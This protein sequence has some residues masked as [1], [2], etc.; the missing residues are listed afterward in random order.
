MQGVVEFLSYLRSLDVH[1]STENGQLNCNAPKGVLTVEL[2]E[3]IKANKFQIISILSNQSSEN[4]LIPIAKAAREG[5]LAPSLQQERLWFL[6]Q[7]EGESSFYNL[8]AGLRLRGTLNRSALENSWKEIL[9]RH[10]VLR[11]A[12]VSVDGHPKSV[13]HTCADWKMDLHSLRE[14][15]MAEQEGAAL[16]F[17]RE[18]LRRPYDLSSAPAIRVCLVELA[19]ND[20]VLLFGAHHIVADGWSLGV[21]T[22]ELTQIYTA[23]CEERASPLPELSIQYLDYAHWHRQMFQSG[24]N[25]AQMAYWKQQ[26]AGSLP[27]TDL[28]SDRPRLQGP[29]YRGMRARLSLPAELLASAKKISLDEDVTLFTTFL[30]VFKIL[31]FR[32]TRETDVIVGS[33]AAGR[34]RPELEKLVGLFLTNLPLR[35]DLSGDPTVRELLARVRE[36]ALNAFS[37]QDVPFGDLVEA[38]QG[39]RDL[40]RTPLFQVMFILQNYR[41]RELQ[42]PDLQ[43][44]P[45]EFDIGT[46]R[47]DLT[48]EAGEVDQQFHMQWEY[49]SD[50]FDD[51][52]IRRMQAHYRRLLEAALAN[53]DQHIS[54]LEM[55]TREEQDQLAATSA[56]EA[57]D[58]PRQACIHDLFA[59]QAARRPEGVAVVFGS[60][61]LSYDE[62]HVRSNRL[63]NRLRALGIGPDSLAGV[64]L[65]RSAEMAV[66]ILGVLKA[67]GA[68]VP[69]D[70]AYPRDRV[71]FMLE[72]S[73]AKVLIT[74]ERL[75]GVLPGHLPSVICLDRDREA[76]RN[77]SEEQPASGVTPENLAYVIYTSGSTGKPKGVEI[78][79][80]S[81]VNFLTSMRREPGLSAH[82]RL[83][84]VTT[85]SF[86]IAGLEFHLPLTTGAYVVIAPQ[87]ALADGAALAQLM[88]ESSITVMQATP[89]TWRLLL[90]SGWEGAKGFKI[91]CG[92]EAIPRELAN[93]LLATG[94]EVWNLYGPTETTIWSTIHRI[95]SRPGSVPIGKPIAN[96][97]IFIL[98]DQRNLAPRGVPGELYIGGDGLARGYRHRAELT[99]ERFVPSPFASGEKLYRTGDLVRRLP[100]G[101][102]EYIGRMDHQV[103]LRGFRI[104]LGEI[105]AAIETQPQVRQAVVIVREDTPNDPRL[106]GYVTLREN[107]NVDG[108]ALRA[109][110]ASRLP[111]Y[112]LPSQWV[113]LNEFP[114]TPNRKVDRRALPVPENKEASSALSAPPTS[115]SEIKVAAIWQELLKHKNVGIHDNFFDLGGNSLLVVQLQ[116][117][118]RKHLGCQISLV[119]LFQKTTV[120][121]IA[122]YVDAQNRNS[123]TL[124]S[125]G[126]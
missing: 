29:S 48:V 16:Q 91:L 88:R 3:Q 111:E 53:P 41:S 21:I 44:A 104:E 35:T 72:D 39:P 71:A 121:A 26:L 73:G 105:E 119:E 58:Y 101:N 90:E 43:A 66:A 7:F 37:H 23:F 61:E 94:A 27:V 47:F 120:S 65:E 55:L 124:Q 98:D 84:A 50:L 89:I 4:E 38:T 97:R 67:G 63:A 49:N 2:K 31:L 107:E 116:S 17:A 36:T 106:T 56:G 93:R 70:P 87:A 18:Y 8:V 83:L 118:L 20:H 68:Y 92:G 51:A 52:T 14:L 12:I 45:M 78:T 108:R 115:E 34:T 77:E 123:G 9:R 85:L 103:K 64:C 57:L 82:D 114:L 86:D 19:D 46:S 99:A 117:R 125:V 28:P 24:A 126:Q 13:I 22:E 62:L 112:M 59:E 40:N 25:R 96:T 1:L 5:F 75:L 60:E 76:L 95:D 100:D 33:V 6:D 113:F 110:L 10:E 42:L 102:V 81:V 122:S 69:L 79:H 109:G 15:P 80:R 74:Q 11:T 54:A 32:Y 30:T